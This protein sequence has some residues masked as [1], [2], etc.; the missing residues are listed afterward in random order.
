MSSTVGGPQEAH[1][2]LQRRDLAFTSSSVPFLSLGLQ[3]WSS[4][5]LVMGERVRSPEIPVRTNASPGRSLPMRRVPSGM[6]RPQ[7]HELF[8]GL[9][10][11]DPGMPSPT[12]RKNRNSPWL[13]ALKIP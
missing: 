12:L 10:P 2:G 3:F 8:H 9:V 1:V 13:W 11:K 5:K 6:P 4:A 7:F